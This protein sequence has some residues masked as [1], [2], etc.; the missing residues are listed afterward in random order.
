[1]ISLGMF[2]TLSRQILFAS[3]QHVTMRPGFTIS[4]RFWLWQTDSWS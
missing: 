4:L 1:M 3:P 2:E